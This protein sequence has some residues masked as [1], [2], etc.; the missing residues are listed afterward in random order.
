MKNAPPSQQKKRISLIFP[1][2]FLF[3]CT[4]CATD[5]PECDGPKLDVSKV[6]GLRQTLFYSGPKASLIVPNPIDATNNPNVQSSDPSLSQDLAGFSLPDI[7]TKRL[8]NSF[9]K[10]RIKDIADDV[11]TLAIPNTQGDYAFAVSDVHYSETMAY[12]SV[13]SMM[14][15]VEGLGFSLVKS[16][17]LYVMVRAP[18]DTGQGS[19]VNAYYSHN[20]LN[21]SLPRT[22]KLF[23]DGQYA[24]AID[25]DMYWHEFGHYVNE[26][27]SRE[28]GIDYAADS[29]A[30]FTEASAL[31]ECLADY[32][33]ESVGNKSD[34]GKWIARNFSSIPAGAPLRSAVAK[35]DD[36]NDFQKVANFNGT[37]KN[38]DR[39]RMGEWCT[40]VLWDLRSQFVQEDPTSGP[41]FS[42]RL[43]YS[44][45]SLLGRDTTMSKFR[46]ALT[47]AD[48]QLH[49]GFHQTSIEKAFT[50]R[51]FNTEPSELAS[52]LT[53]Q[54][55][56]VGLNAQGDKLVLGTPSAGNQVSFQM[57]ITNSNN[58][59]ARNV[60]VR[61][62]S[63]DPMLV[64]V[65][66]LQGYGDLPSGS[67]IV[68]GQGGLSLDYAV[69]GTIDASVRTRTL[70][71][72]LRVQPENGP[73]TVY[74]GEIQL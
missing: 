45:V 11:S 63:S 14:H 49:C 20:Y 30:A 51:G 53:L 4:R 26:S 65:A 40:R 32:L 7:V 70:P 55:S 36:F 35:S 13:S 38:L 21:P 29:G 9:L 2:L 59:T 10:V 12:Y 28:V 18:S 16:R 19:T 47:T 68:V 15:Y 5:L 67:S 58:N 22:I 33:A 24:P 62:E 72:R 42:D 74:E 69:Y 73:E 8:E 44:A 50:S 56:P 54:V 57:K 25:R 27:I 6:T 3:L 23:G 41:I 60:R 71:Y 31:H 39:Y 34:I 1:I 46:Q 61:M 43:I 66:Y 17:P 37:D 52:K 48:Q 64:P